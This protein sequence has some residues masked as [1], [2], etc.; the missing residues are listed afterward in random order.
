MNLKMFYDFTQVLI[1]KKS[2]STKDDYFS[3]HILYTTKIE[4]KA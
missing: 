4:I 2:Y 1:I 3:T